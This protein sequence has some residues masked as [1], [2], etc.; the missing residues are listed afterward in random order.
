[1]SAGEA[2]SAQPATVKVGPKRPGSEN[3]LLLP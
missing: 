2:A 3:D 1:V